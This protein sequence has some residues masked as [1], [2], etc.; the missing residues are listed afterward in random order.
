MKLPNILAMQNK[1]TEKTFTTSLVDLVLNCSSISSSDLLLWPVEIYIAW[2]GDRTCRTYSIHLPCMTF[3]HCFYFHLSLHIW[4][5]LTCPNSYFVHWKI[6]TQWT[7]D[8][9]WH[10]NSAV[11][12]YDIRQTIVPMSLAHSDR[13]HVLEYGIEGSLHLPLTKSITVR[14]LSQNPY[15]QP[16]VSSSQKML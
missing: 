12:C 2:I 9:K 1:V 4:L 6:V 13:I 5:N 16:A 3:W 7:H 10:W 15:I 8:E 11:S 14:S